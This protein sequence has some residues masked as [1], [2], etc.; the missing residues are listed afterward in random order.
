LEGGEELSGG[1]K[2]GW[3]NLHVCISYTAPRLHK[4]GK[5]G[6]KGNVMADEKVRNAVACAGGPPGGETR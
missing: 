5:R 4:G 2:F 3:Q 1:V 6:S